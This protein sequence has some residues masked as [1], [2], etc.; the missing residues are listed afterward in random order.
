MSP[1][2]R[3]GPTTRLASNDLGVAEVPEL[4]KPVITGSLAFHYR[5]GGHKAV[6]AEWKAFLDFADRHYRAA[7]K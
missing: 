3:P 7:A 2:P 6:P 1:S 4:D 5:R